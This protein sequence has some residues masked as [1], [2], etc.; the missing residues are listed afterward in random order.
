M[1][2]YSLRRC[3]FC[4]S[5]PLLESHLLIICVMQK[6]H[7]LL[8]KAKVHRNIEIFSIFLI[9]ITRAT[10]NLHWLVRSCLVSKIFIKELP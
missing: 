10:N 8:S 5:K 6:L 1:V 4:F 2:K 9:N 3:I 7:L